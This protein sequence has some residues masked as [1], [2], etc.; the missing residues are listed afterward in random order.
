MVSHAGLGA[1]VAITSRKNLIFALN[2]RWTITL[3]PVWY[4]A[5]RRWWVI[6]FATKTPII[7]FLNT[8]LNW[9]VRSWL[10]LVIKVT[11]RIF[12]LILRIFSTIILGLSLIL[13]FVFLVSIFT[14]ILRLTKSKLT[15]FC[16]FN[17]WF[18]KLISWLY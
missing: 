13:W 5:F 3:W 6:E 10:V 17:C 14:L 7:T 2:A 9:C 11:F 16:Y 12:S 15:K 8:H 4:P 1:W 18:K